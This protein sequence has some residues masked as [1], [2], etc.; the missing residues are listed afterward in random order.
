MGKF[1]TPLKVG[2]LTIIAVGAFVFALRSVEQGVL[3]GDTYL[4][5]AIFD[6]VLGVAKRSRVVMAG[7]EVGYIDS[8]EL[9]GARARLTI[10]SKSSTAAPVSQ[11]SG[12]T[13]TLLTAR[14]SGWRRICHQSLT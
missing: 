7:I 13:R 4:V 9:S 8:I 5:Y 2:I 10:S 6:D 11:Y 3:G 1:F 14:H 12:S